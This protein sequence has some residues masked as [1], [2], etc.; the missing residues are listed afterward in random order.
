MFPSAHGPH[1]KEK[2]SLMAVL[3]ISGLLA[4][5]ASVRAPHSCKSWPP[6][7]SYRFK[8]FP[9]NEL[10]PSP[11]ITP[12]HVREQN[13]SRSIIQL[14]RGVLYRGPYRVRTWPSRYPSVELVHF[15]GRPRS[16]ERTAPMLQCNHR[17]ILIFGRMSRQNAAAL[18]AVIGR[19]A[20]KMKPV[21]FRTTG[22]R[23][24]RQEISDEAHD[25]RADPYRLVVEHRR[26]PGVVGGA[27]L[28]D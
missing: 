9:E 11:E 24:V 10:I 22:G 16:S 8:N 7:S 23:R 3:V 20:S 13:V 21:V 1:E 6:I 18:H 25:G 26:H 17:L 2:L 4:W 12:I 27:V 19:G 14:Q 5:S 28:G 15:N